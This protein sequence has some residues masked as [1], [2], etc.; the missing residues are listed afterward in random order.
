MPA[1]LVLIW[2]YDSAIG[3]INST[4]PYNY[5]IRPIYEEIKNVDEILSISRTL[6]LKMT[7]A[8]VGFVAES[9]VYPFNNSDQIKKILP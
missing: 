5:N 3:Q 9:G 2:D 7:F 4:L 8:C 1:Q 6:N